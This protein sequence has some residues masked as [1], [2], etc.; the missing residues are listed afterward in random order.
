VKWNIRMWKTWE[1]WTRRGYLAIA[2][3]IIG[4][5]AASAAIGA[6]WLIYH[7][8]QR[9][10]SAD[11]NRDLLTRAKELIDSQDASLRVGGM[12]SLGQI[13]KDSQTDRPMV[14][15]VLAAYVRTHA[16][17]TACSAPSAPDKTVEVDVQAALT[18]IGQ[19]DSDRDHPIDL[20]NS[21]LRGANLES[22]WL[23]WADLS[24]TNL[25][26]GTLY[27]VNLS[28][29]NLTGAQLSGAAIVGGAKLGWA[30]LSSAILTGA[31]LGPSSETDLQNITYNADTAWP[32]GFI[33]P[34]SHH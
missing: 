26:N 19:F 33:P 12:E 6:L 34:P 8:N 20:A 11:R 29:A 3:I 15:E 7:A 1:T 2:Q 5:V 24:G 17:I 18:V 21:C 22:A 23:R 9:Y 32:A 31:T 16:P 4:V 25:T 30:N 10:E 14:L 28:G 27:R 13:A